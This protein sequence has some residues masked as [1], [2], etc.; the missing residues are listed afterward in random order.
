VE[1]D[2]ALA[3]AQVVGAEPNVWGEIDELLERR[4][5][6]A[7]DQSAAIVTVVSATWSA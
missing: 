4:S 7:A 5:P 2:P 3:R 1:E 6:T